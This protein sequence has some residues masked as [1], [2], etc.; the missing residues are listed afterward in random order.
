MTE[1]TQHPPV[2]VATPSR[3]ALIALGALLLAI[4]GVI[5]I[6]TH[7]GPKFAGTSS[8]YVVE[9]IFAA[10]LVAGLAV[11]LELA[12][13]AEGR[14]SAISGWVA[15]LSQA[16]VA[17]AVLV[18]VIES[19]EALNRVYIVGTLLWIAGSLA[20][21]LSRPRHRWQAIALVPAVIIALAFFG[22]GGTLA[23]ALVWA[24]IAARP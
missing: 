3:T 14:A 24:L 23:L 1:T 5:A 12:R 18:T 17:T 15:A 8:D 2:A 6:A 20:L 11:P 21:G 7:Q 16:C 13:R 9:S 4:D 19:K 10:G 22:V